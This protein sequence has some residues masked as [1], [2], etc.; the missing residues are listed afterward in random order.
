MFCGFG[1]AHI[2]SLR[3]RCTVLMDYGDFNGFDIIILF[4]ALTLAVIVTFF[5]A[6]SLTT[7]LAEA[8]INNEGS[9]FFQH[10]MLTM[11]SMRASYQREREERDRK[12]NNFLAGGDFDD[13]QYDCERLQ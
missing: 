10:F 2:N 4:A 13:S 9:V 7:K 3:H 1:C 6:L 5:Y 8:E 11:N 12:K